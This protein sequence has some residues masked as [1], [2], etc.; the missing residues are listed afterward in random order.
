[1]TAHRKRR[2]FVAF[3]KTNMTSSLQAHRQQPTRRPD[4]LLKFVV[5]LSE[6]GLLL[7]SSNV[8]ELLLKTLIIVRAAVIYQFMEWRKELLE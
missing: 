8:Q 4:S 5:A 1:M 2:L 7:I 3:T 6:L